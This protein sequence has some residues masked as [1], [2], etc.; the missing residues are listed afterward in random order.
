MLVRS[1][2]R[3]E[4]VGDA[5]WAREVLSFSNFGVEETGADR[6]GTGDATLD[7]DS[8]RGLKGS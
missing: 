8:K 6:T 7:L 1:L 4:I 3:G 5:G 2:G